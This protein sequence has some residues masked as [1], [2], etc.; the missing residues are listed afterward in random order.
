MFPARL[1]LRDCRLVRGVVHRS[2][3]RHWAVAAAALRRTGSTCP[4]PW[5]DKGPPI[6]RVVGSG[7][8]DPGEGPKTTPSENPQAR[9]PADT[10]LA[11]LPQADL[12]WRSGSATSD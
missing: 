4:S 10:P 5:A 1:A 7:S 3:R 11:R 9:S 6:D 8:N 12:L 2:A